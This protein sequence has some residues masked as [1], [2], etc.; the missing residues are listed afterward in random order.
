MGNSHPQANPKASIN[1]LIVPLGSLQGGEADYLGS[2]VSR[3]QHLST[4]SYNHLR[5][6]VGVSHHFGRVGG[7]AGHHP[8]LVF[9]PPPHVIRKNQKCHCFR[10]QLLWQL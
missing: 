5:A 7:E 2:K 10:R 8:V 4:V 3:S 6:T 9:Q 1:L